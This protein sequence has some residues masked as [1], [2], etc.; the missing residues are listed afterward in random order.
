MY[1]QCM[2]IRDR[3]LS[4]IVPLIIELTAS[5]HIYINY[6]WAPLPSRRLPD[7]VLYHAAPH[8]GANKSW[9]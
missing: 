9:P 4:R 2:R 6:E 3:G 1:V 5:L 7:F 8:S